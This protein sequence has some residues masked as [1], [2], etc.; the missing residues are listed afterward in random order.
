[1]PER[2]GLRGRPHVLER[3]FWDVSIEPA[4]S[5]IASA[6]HDSRSP[7]R[8]RSRAARAGSQRRPDPTSAGWN[9]TTQPN[10]IAHRTSSLRPMSERLVAPWAVTQSLDD[11]AGRVDRDHPGPA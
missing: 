1:M 10:Q 2:V 7:G 11:E 5:R 3:A 9:A 8:R 4:H 6:N